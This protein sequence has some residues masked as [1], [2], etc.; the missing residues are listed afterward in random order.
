MTVRIL[1]SELAIWTMNYQLGTL[2]SSNF[3]RYIKSFFLR[4]CTFG[5]A[6]VTGTYYLPAAL[7]VWS[8]MLVLTLDSAHVGASLLVNINLCK[9]IKKER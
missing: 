2:V 9:Q 7:L 8:N 5:C 6:R 4:F 3:S 1:I